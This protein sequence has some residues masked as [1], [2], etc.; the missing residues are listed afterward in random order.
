MGTFQTVPFKNETDSLRGIEA[1][2]N[3]HFYSLFP[4]FPEELTLLIPD[5]RV[6]RSAGTEARGEKATKGIRGIPDAILIRF[7]HRHPDCPFQIHL[8]EYECYGERKTT[9]RDKTRYLNEHIIP[10]L[11]R[12][13]SAFSVINDRHIREQTIKTW[14]DKIIDYIFSDPAKQQKAGGWIKQI[15]G[16]SEQMIAREIDRFLVE[17]FK[18]RLKI[19]LVID[20]LSTE[21]RETIKNMIQAFRLEDGIAVEFQAFVVRLEQ[22]INILDQDAEHALSVQ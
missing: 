17:A 16:R 1:L 22:R 19:M 20:Y 18:R 6:F 2:V 3:N 21:Q 14:V 7:N 15:G 5:N 8:V 12:F 9:S 4:A 11:V 13:A 10:Q